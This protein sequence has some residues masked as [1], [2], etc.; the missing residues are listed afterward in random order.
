MEKKQQWNMTGKPTH[1]N[2][3]LMPMNSSR[4]GI[5]LD[6]PLVVEK[7]SLME[8]KNSPILS[9]TMQDIL[10]DM[11]K[12]KTYEG[13]F[14]ETWK[15]LNIMMALPVSTATVERTFSQMKLIKTR[16]R[17]RLSDSNLEHLMKIVIEGP[18]ISNV[19]FNEI[20]DIFKQKNR[21]IL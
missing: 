16:L 9:P 15:L 1:P 4:S 18:S 7:K 8:R 14:P 10:E 5:S 17:N 19:D 21:R 3:L 6:V 11:M 20:L 13:V 2:H 12:S